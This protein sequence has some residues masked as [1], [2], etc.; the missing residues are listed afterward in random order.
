MSITLRLK[1]RE[2]RR[3]M[4]GHAWVFS[5]EIDTAHTPLKGLE[6]GSAVTLETANGKFLAHAYVNPHSLIAARVTS[7]RANHPFNA[8]VLR[9]RLSLALALRQSRYAEP[10]YRL[11]H[12]EGDFLPGLTVDRYDHVLVVQITSAGMELY[13]DDIVDSLQALTGA[14]AIFLRNDAP[15]RELE[16][17]PSY[18]EWVVG[19]PVDVLTIREN[20]LHYQ[21]PA[22]VS[23]KTGWF[24]DHRDSR[25][26]LAPWVKGRRVLD[27]Y[28][29]LGGFG[30]NALAF[31]ASSVLA[32]D[33]SAPATQ[34]AMA[35]AALNNMQDRFSAQCN[36]AVEAMR[37]LFEEGERYDVIILDPPAFIKRRKDREQGL[38]HYALNNRLAM[39]LL[40]PGGILLSA[41]CS[42]ALSQDELLQQMRQGA[43][44]SSLGLQVLA[45]LQQ[46]ADHPVNISMPETL[47]LTGAIARLV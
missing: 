1:K 40:V 43:P 47:Y 7:W 5:N 35:N 10:F 13:R 9:E 25:L 17:L 46:G 36:D 14:T 33:A 8:T 18:R 30:L 16:H 37:T 34:A 19:E 4:R 26:S 11:V 6:P 3:V 44:K 45:P 12:S 22:D 2:E 39:R 29:Y 20:S 42:Q 38:R 32:I 23:Q 24:Y 21:V 41:S 15:V 28:S 31:G 27:V